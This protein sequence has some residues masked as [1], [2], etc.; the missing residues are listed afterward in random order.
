[1]IQGGI[2]KRLGSLRLTGLGLFAI[3]G[4]KVFFSD[5]AYLDQFYRIVAFILLGILILCGAFVY[6]KYRQTF[7]RELVGPDRGTTL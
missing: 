5:L 6:L 3:V 7:A 4:L 1:M 2:L